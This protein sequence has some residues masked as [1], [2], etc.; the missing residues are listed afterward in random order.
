MRLDEASPVT[1]NAPPDPI[2]DSFAECA[3]WRV[4][5]SHH[6]GERAH[7]NLQELAE[8]GLEIAERAL[9]GRPQR[10]V[11]LCDSKVTVFAFAKGRSSSYRL[12]G[13]LRKIAGH[14]IFG[15]VSL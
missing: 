14:M 4:V 8:L 3:P 13:L 12:N 15:C 7:V 1:T 6:F 2:L 10:L 11:N 9:E 5:R